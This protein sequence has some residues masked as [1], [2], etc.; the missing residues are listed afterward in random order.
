MIIDKERDNLK[1]TVLCMTD[2]NYDDADKKTVA[3]MI[4]P[5]NSMTHIRS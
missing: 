4:G 1:K 2:N 3:L 5:V